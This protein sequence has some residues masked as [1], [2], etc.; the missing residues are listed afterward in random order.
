VPH[1]IHKITVEEAW[2]E[3]RRIFA[4]VVAPSRYLAMLSADTVSSRTATAVP[5]Q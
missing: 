1:C 3:V 2:N 4:E 5:E